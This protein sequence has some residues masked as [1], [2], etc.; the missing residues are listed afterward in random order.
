MGL[1]LSKLQERLERLKLREAEVRFALRALRRCPNT[2]TA[3]G[4]PHIVEFEA[5]LGRAE[6]GAWAELLALLPR[7]VVHLTRLAQF[8]G[9]QG[10]EVLALMA[11][12]LVQAEGASGII[13]EELLRA[14]LEALEPDQSVHKALLEE[15]S[16]TWTFLMAF[17]AE[18]PDC[19]AWVRDAVAEKT[20]DGLR[21]L[22]HADRRAR[23]KCLKRFSRAFLHPEMARTRS[24]EPMPLSVADFIGEPEESLPQLSPASPKLAAT[25]AWPAGKEV[26]LA[27]QSDSPRWTRQEQM[28]RRANTTNCAPGPTADIDSIASSLVESLVDAADAA[29]PM[30]CRLAASLASFGEQGEDL[31]A[32]L[33]LTH[34]LAPALLK[35][36]LGLG[37]GLAEVFPVLNVT[38]TT[39]SLRSLAQLLTSAVTRA[40]DESETK[41][42]RTLTQALAKRGMAQASAAQS[43]EEPPSCVVCRASELIALG[44][45]LSTSA[46]DVAEILSMSPDKVRLLGRR[47]SSSGSTSAVVCWLKRGSPATHRAS[48][49]GEEETGTGGAGGARAR[50]L[51]L[52]ETKRHSDRTLNRREEAL[53]LLRQLLREPRALCGHGVGTADGALLAALAPARRGTELSR[54]LKIQLLQEA[55]LW[56]EPSSSESAAPE[57]VTE[58][59]LF[60][61]LQESL[62]KERTAVTLLGRQ[63]RQRRQLVRVTAQQCREVTACLR[64]CA[65]AAWSLRFNSCLQT[66]W[67]PGPGGHGRGQ[68]T[69]L[70]LPELCVLGPERE[71]SAGSLVNPERSPRPGSRRRK[72]DGLFGIF[73]QDPDTELEVAQ[74][75]RMVK[76]NFC[77]YHRIAAVGASM[78]VEGLANDASRSHCPTRNL[79][80][81][82]GAL[83]L[84]RSDRDNQERLGLAKVIQELVTM[85]SEIISNHCKLSKQHQAIPVQDPEDEEWARPQLLLQGSE[86]HLTQSVSR[87]VFHQLHHRLFPTEPTAED[88]RIHLQIQR[89]WWLRPRHLDLQKA[90]A[91]TEQASEAVKLLQRLHSLRSPNEMLEVMAQAFRITTQAACLKSQ[92]A[93][94]ICKTS[95]DNAFGADEALPLFILII[96][97]ANPR[98]LDSV[99]SYAERFT[100]SDQRRTEQGYALAQAQSAVEFSKRCRKEQLSNLKPGEWESHIESDDPPP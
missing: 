42:L 59:E 89:L 79:R 24:Q 3:Y 55:L 20:L 69:E 75:L 90:L 80:E 6:A 1:E 63:L 50:P 77:P 98:M 96:I 62:Q 23:S 57:T 11:A 15:G 85:V 93:E 56:Q 53:I 31:L 91:E 99:L 82:I 48:P 70:T 94:G 10:T 65:K 52:S 95:Q 14:Q 46:E 51:R 71:A 21:Q 54:Q 28:V 92:L 44:T 49:P 100:T 81:I 2:P 30:L 83:R 19:E 37:L 27:D 73:S 9:R 29:P 16:F 68:R 18:D 86:Q 67:E 25:T 41:P 45:S 32:T 87:F 13:M 34:W 26:E 12:A 72:R 88:N 43:H 35:P 38:E 97:R 8:S 17:S 66:V 33:L 84:F 47:P 5:L 64:R 39:Y 61:L 60:N 36:S 78:G 40:G 76:T 7:H 74:A 58:Q 4:T 22:L